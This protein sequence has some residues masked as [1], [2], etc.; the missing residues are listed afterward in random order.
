MT[1]FSLKLVA[2]FCML[3]DHT[4]KVLLTKGILVPYLG[5]EGDLW[6]RTIMTFL[7][8]MSFPIFAW[9]TA[10]G[11]KHTKR[12]VRYLLRLLLFAAASEVPFQLCF[13]GA[14]ETGVQLACHN[15]IFTMLLGAGAIL[16]GRWLEEHGVPKLLADILP[17]I[18]A[19]ALGWFLYTDYN[20]WG[21]GLIIFLYYL[22]GE[23]EQLLFL[24]CWISVFQLIWHGWT[25]HTFLWLSRENYGK[26]LLQ[27]LGAMLSV[28]FLAAYN[29]QQGRR[30][31]WLF[32][33]FYPAHLTALFL[34]TLF[35][36][37]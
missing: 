17:A 35:I 9:F 30:A 2:L 14:Y 13:Y 21:V 22:P 34:L 1:Q 33:I 18:L 16:S 29:G 15:V 20:A 19:I 31:K 32:Y 25:G 3:L 24:A 27:W 8:R 11:C 23:K 4:A 36:A 7:G 6:L 37:K 12:P 10:E 26:L 28:G 5:V